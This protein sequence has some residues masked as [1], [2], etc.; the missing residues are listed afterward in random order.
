MNN[1][2]IHIEEKLARMREEYR[3]ASHAMKA[4]LSVGG[5]LLND[6]KRKLLNKEVERNAEK[7]I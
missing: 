6:R 4:W 7:L 5:S 2:L 3:V 1:E